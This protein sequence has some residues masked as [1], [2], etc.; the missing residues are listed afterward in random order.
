MA[1]ALRLA[2]VC[3][4]SVLLGAEWFAWIAGYGLNVGLIVVA[5]IALVVMV[6]YMVWRDCSLEEQVDDLSTSHI[7]SN[8][9]FSKQWREMERELY[10]LKIAYNQLDNMYK[11]CFQ[12]RADLSKRYTEWSKRAEEKEKLVNYA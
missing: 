8:N 5:A 11:Q 12:E 10:D 9:V 1:N 6:V 3:F 7:V 4:L 2:F